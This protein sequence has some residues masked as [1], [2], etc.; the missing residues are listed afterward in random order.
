MFKSLLLKAH[1]LHF[2]ASTIK[3]SRGKTKAETSGSVS[4]APITLQA[5]QSGR[6]CNGIIVLFLFLCA[7]VVNDLHMLCFPCYCK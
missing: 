3:P 4:R 6:C 7:F 1:V 5:L 2:D